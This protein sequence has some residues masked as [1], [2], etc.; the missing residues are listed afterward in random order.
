MIELLEEQRDACN[1]KFRSR[2]TQ[3]VRID[4]A[5]WLR[6]VQ[7]RIAK[8]VDL[9]DEQL[10]ERSRIA[11]TELYDISLDLFAVG[12][13][14]DEGSSIPLLRMWDELLPALGKWIARDPRRVVGCMCNATLKIS[15]SDLQT[16]HRWIECMK[17]VGPMADSVEQ[18]LGI[19]KM[20]A[21]RSGLAEYRLAALRI[22]AS[23]PAAVVV[24]ILD[25]V[26]LVSESDVRTLICRMEKDPWCLPPEG[27]S[28]GIQLKNV[29]GQFLFGQFAGYGGYFFHPPVVY[30]IEGHLCVTDRKQVWRMDADIF[31][32]R[33]HKIE[34]APEELRDR[35]KNPTVEVDSRGRVSWDGFVSNHPELANASSYACDGTTLAVTIPTSF[36]VFLLTRAK[37]EG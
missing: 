10:P 24:K 4:V 16:A 32:F 5:I 26:V 12:H 11:L 2:L 9:I 27:N 7:E 6:H 14:S 33:L 34:M 37:R 20:A 19:G 8:I 28:Y 1:E 23:L 17:S 25:P 21:W 31:G 15:Q 29:S 30:E 13:L 18:L 22:A 36:H 3:G 35:S